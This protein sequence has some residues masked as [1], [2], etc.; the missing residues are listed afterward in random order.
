MFGRGTG[1]SWA[2]PVLDVNTCTIPLSHYSLITVNVLESLCN[3]FSMIIKIFNS[4]E[5]QGHKLIFIQKMTGLPDVTVLWQL[6]RSIRDDLLGIS[7]RK[8]TSPD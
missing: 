7:V 2:V 8:A 6:L 1:Y 3:S 5:C 4:T